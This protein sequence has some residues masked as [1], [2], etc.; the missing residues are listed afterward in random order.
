[1]SHDPKMEEDEHNMWGSGS[2]WRDSPSQICMPISSDNDKLN[3]GRRFWLR[4][5]CI[6]GCKFRMP[7]GGE[8]F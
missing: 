2:R 7:V 4:S 1:M 6:Y 3:P 8:K 5:Q